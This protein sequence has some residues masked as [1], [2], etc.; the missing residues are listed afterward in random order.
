MFWHCSLRAV[1]SSV[2]LPSLF[3]MVNVLTRFSFSATGPYRSCTIALCH[4]RPSLV[5][6]LISFL[7]FSPDSQRFTS[8][9]L[10]RLLGITMAISPFLLSSNDAARAMSSMFREDCMRHV[11]LPLSLLLRL[12]AKASSGMGSK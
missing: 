2:G 11:F 8:D 7:R 6:T 12:P 9:L 3:R 1:Y 5:Y 4:D 10:Q